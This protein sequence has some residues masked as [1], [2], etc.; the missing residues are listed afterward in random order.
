MNL[1]RLLT[2]IVLVLCSSCAFTQNSEP[3]I[4]ANFEK[5]V[6]LSNMVSY[7]FKSESSLLSEIQ[8]S[9]TWQGA[10]PDQKPEQ[11]FVLWVKFKI[12]NQQAYSKELRLLAGNV[13][14]DQVD[15][16]VLDEFGRI[17]E[18]SSS[19][20]TLGS[21]PDGFESNGFKIDFSVRSESNSI[22]YLRLKNDSYKALPIELWESEAHKNLVTTRLVLLGA[23]AGALSIIA[24]YFL[25]T[26]MLKNAAARFWFCV[27]SVSVMTTILTA[28]GILAAIFQLPDYIAE[29]TS[30]S[31]VATFFASIKIARIIFAPMSKLWLRAHYLLLTLPIV[32]IFVLDDYNQFLGLLIFATLFFLSKVCATL[33]YRSG[34]DVRSAAI[35]LSAWLLLGL[36]GLIE[37]IGFV[38]VHTDVQNTQPYPFV[39]VCL[40]VTLIGVAI[41]SREQS[42]NNLQKQ[43]QLSKIDDLKA[44]QNLYLHSAEGL[45]TAYSNGD[46]IKVNPAVCALFG[47]V[48]SEELLKSRSNLAQLFAHKQ[49]ADLM[50]GELSIQRTVLGREVKGTRR[51]GTEFW[52]SISCQLQKV[53]STLMHFGSLFD[54]T[55]RRL[56]QMNL[57]YINTH[58]QLTGLFNRRH[59]LQ[60]VTEKIT[61]QNQPDQQNALLY[62]DVNQFKVINDACGY[63]AGDIFIKEISHELFDVVLDKYPFARLNADQFALFVSTHDNNE[64]KVL[65]DQLIT[66]IKGFKFKWDKHS[67]EQGISIG[68]CPVTKDIPGSEELLSYASTAC[69]L[70][71]QDPTNDICFYNAESQFHEG[72]TREA[73]WVNTVLSAIDEDKFE[74]F[75]Q[76]YRPLNRVVEK[77]YY[78]ILLRLRTQEDDLIAPEMFM[79]A[80]EKINMSIKVDKIVIDKFFSWLKSNNSHLQKLN[81]ANINLSGASIRNDEFR[82]YLLNAFEKYNIPYHKICFEITET[83]SVIN[84]K[85]VNEFMRDFR[86]L[87]CSFGLDDFGSGFSSYSYLKHLPVDYVKIDGQFIRNI[88]HDP[89]DLAMVTSIRDI[90]RAM[91]IETVAELVESSEILVEVGKLGVDYAQGFGVAQPMPLSKYKDFKQSD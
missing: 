86:R 40:G 31:L 74:L 55:E 19:Q 68:I 88:L 36:T 66:R 38:N 44:Y 42:I 45:Y 52:L 60:I 54:I 62:L 72:F 8:Q 2:L 39:F 14:I 59:F 87:G 16:F 76:H 80:A 58:D 69:Q 70:A 7:Q 25:F 91:N 5:A 75:Y 83:I 28:E 33:V 79:P 63:T 26:Y 3:T 65:A 37:F 4:S 51:D 18:S 30:L 89:I 24:S 50:L 73:Y 43:K 46:L 71:K 1:Y 15:A 67:F 17:L 49:E 47:Y 56:D 22:I 6:N 64:L 20:N 10:I 41:I 9:N 23:L 12:S 11:D 61:N 21:N 82:Y 35:Y 84:T 81:K 77:E 34:I 53:N 27:F 13:F 48:N 57:Q 90:A 29:L 32:S 78:E 85:S